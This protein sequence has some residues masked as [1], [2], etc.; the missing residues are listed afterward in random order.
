MAKRYYNLE[1]ETKAYL[2][3]CDERS[4]VSST[5]TTTVNDYA[6]KQKAANKFILLTGNTLLS[7]FG[8]TLSGLTIL[9]DPAL[10]D[11]WTGS[12]FNDIFS[13]TSFIKHLTL[14]VP[15]YSIEFNTPSF[16]YK[17]STLPL[18]SNSTIAAITPTLS[19]QEY[20]RFA[21]FR[22]KSFNSTENNNTGFQPIFGNAYS[23]DQI[24]MGLC[25]STTGKLAFNQYANFTVNPIRQATTI[26]NLNRWYFGGFTY[27]KSLSTIKFYLNGI[28]DGTVTA[29]NYGNANTNNLIIGGVESTSEPRRFFDGYIGPILHY[30]RVL[31]DTEILQT[32]NSYKSRFSL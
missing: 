24:D 8:I 5:A 21:V 20:S 27:S 18:Y 16:L 14:T 1:K 25:T 15:E 17:T 29:V 26:L 19:S 12:S 6:I 11:S 22:C 4:I 9:A 28:L 32:F 3:A 31:S 13:N 2:K 7:R 10:P 30:N 23:G